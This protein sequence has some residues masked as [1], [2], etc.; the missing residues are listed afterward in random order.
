MRFTSKSVFILSV[1][2]S[3]STLSAFAP[4][5]HIPGRD[6]IF[7]KLDRSTSGRGNTM[8]MAEA[9]IDSD[10]KR[11]SGSML[12]VL[13]N[14]ERWISETLGQHKKAGPNPHSRK[15]VSYVC[16]NTKDPIMTVA[17]I[18]RQV[19][20]ARELGESH[21]ITEEDMM[22][23][24]GS[25]YVPE[26]LRQT[27][28]LV[29][30]WCDSF[31]SFESFEAVYQ[32]INLARRAAR[33]YVTDMSCEKYQMMTDGNRNDKDWNVSVTLASLHPDYGVETKGEA[34]RENEGQKVEVDMKLDE[35]NRKR[36]LARQSPYPTLALEMKSLPPKA[37]SPPIEGS[38][39][40]PGSDEVGGSSM[41]AVN[42]LEAMYCKST[43]TTCDIKDYDQIGSIYGYEVE[44]EDSPIDN[45][46]I[47]AKEW[48][49]EN[50]PIYDPYASS[51]VTTDTEEVDAAYEDVFTAIATHENL[52]LSSQSVYIMMPHFLSQSATSLEK[53]SWE[54]FNI[55]QK[56]GLNKLFSVSIFHPEHVLPEKRCAVPTV[57]FQSYENV[58]RYHQP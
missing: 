44:I 43:V 9:G 24:K 13:A 39:S 58:L 53:F 49:I 22:I 50:D 6:V 19:K 37:H 34:L 4:T 56:L 14:T 25:D 10:P 57:V 17:N 21:S 8:I 30:P 15:E 20:E 51:F 31:Q 47:H 35:F 23:D 55:L 52:D 3:P 27:Q 40:N 41:D 11:N 42:I 46:L 38:S 32:A 45:A 12:S 16:E 7:S 18:F 2:V 33:D 36:V 5:N 29:I 48:L 54:V 28:V 1:V 26:T